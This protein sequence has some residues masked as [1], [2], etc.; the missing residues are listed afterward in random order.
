MI[1]D[2]KEAQNRLKELKKELES[3][4]DINIKSFDESTKDLTKLNTHIKAARALLQDLKPDLDYI[5]SS[6]NESI[7][8]LQKTNY[9]IELQKKGLK[10]IVSQADMITSIK[11]GEL[12]TDAKSIK[13]QQEKYK[14][15]LKNL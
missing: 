12:D 9:F 2:I 3:F 4:D 15:N 1:K 5:S 14:I 10:G 6:F 13:K 7:N 8:S 11:Q